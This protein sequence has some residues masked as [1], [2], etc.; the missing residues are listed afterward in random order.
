MRLKP[1]FEGM[2]FAPQWYHYLFMV[3]LFPLSL[4]YGSVMWVR[5]VLSRRQRYRLPIISVGNLQVGGS[6]KTPFV[7]ALAS[8]YR[9]VYI[10]SRGY[11][12]QSHG[13]LKVSEQGRILVDVTQSGDEA[14]LMALSLPSVSLIVSEDRTE[15]IETAIA[16]GAGLIV[17]DDGFNRVEVEKFEILLEPACRPNSLP[18]PAGG[19]REFAFST[20]YADVVAQEERDFRRIV[21]VVDATERMVLVTAISNP[22]RLDPYLPHGVVAKVYLDDHAYFEEA[23][24]QKLLA[25]HHATAILCTQKDYVKM[26]GF[27]LSISQMKLKLAID[28]AIFEKI[29]TYIK[30]EG[31]PTH[32]R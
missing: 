11:G 5:R 25:D 27:K 28:N 10:I 13:C 29:E 32:E 12:R 30:Q 8:R 2:F 21:E 4:L 14:M 6:G 18:F 26:A 22:T 16:E 3:L 9:G 23:T 24:L 15:A 19:L 20:R 31:Y 1:F 17:L 7:I